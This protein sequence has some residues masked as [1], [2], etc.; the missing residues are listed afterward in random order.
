MTGTTVNCYSSPAISGK[1]RADKLE[2]ELADPK[3]GDMIG[4]AA[5]R[6]S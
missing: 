2:I 5:A 3:V 1:N 6:S 4:Q